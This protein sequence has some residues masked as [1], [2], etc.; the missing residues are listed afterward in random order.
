MNSLVG[1]TIDFAVEYR[2]V[3]PEADLIGFARLWVTGKPLG[4]FGDTTSLYVLYKDLLWLKEN[5]GDMPELLLSPQEV[6]NFYTASECAPKNIRHLYLG[7]AFDDFVVLAVRSRENVHFIWELDAKPF[8]SY[9]GLSSG[10]D[11]GCV[12][13]QSVCNV[14]TG[15]GK[16]LGLADD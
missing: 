6:Y 4:F 14:A 11:S 7:E 5:I 16:K 2:V 3:Q 10:I 1:S 9:E 13:Y 8:F 12:P 15:L